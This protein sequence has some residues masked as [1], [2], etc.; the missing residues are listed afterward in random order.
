MMSMSSTPHNKPALPSLLI[1]IPEGIIDLGWGHP[2][3][4]LHPIEALRRAAEIALADGSPVPL[5]Y[6]A[7][8]GYGPLIHSLTEFLSAQSSYPDGVSPNELFLTAGASQAIDHATT[9]FTQVGDTVFVEEPTYYL[10]Q[11]IFEDHGLN[12]VGVP[13]DGDGLRP[14][15]LESMLQSPDVPR[16]KMLYIIPTYQNP[17]G[18]VLPADRR[19]RLVELAQR[20]GFV[21]IADEVYH[22][23]HYGEPPPP[24]IASLDD[25]ADG[26]VIS[27]GSFSKI[28]GPGLR[29]GWMHARPA[30]IQRFANAG[31]TISGGGLNH[32]TST[33]VHAVVEQG[34]LSDNI[35]LLRRTYGERVSA[36]SAAL[37]EQL[38]DV[39]EFT[40]PG[41][42]Y[43]FWLT[44]ND[45]TNAD[46]L[47]PIAQECGVNYRPGTAFSA[48][49]AFPN[50]IRLAF[51]LYEP[52]TLTEG[53]RR[54]AEAHKALRDI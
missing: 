25:S 17:S 42:G 29:T 32:F 30:I 19:E 31:L 26:C 8:Q 44:F 48:S 2:S 14:D 39:V 47:L 27:L 40:A 23:L 34:M 12:V 5:Q 9:L 33:L 3:P 37:R 49:G 53:I 13:T 35:A 46:A 16:P 15:A 54:I 7:P 10:I 11:S 22:L 1:S 43:F 28:L 6:G 24:P 41:G 50:A 38:G 4:R 45:G 21:V 51:A 52:D 18:S 20:Y 36:M